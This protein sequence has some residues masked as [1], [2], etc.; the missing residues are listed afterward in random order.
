MKAS[1]TSRLDHN[2]SSKDS[3]FGRFSYDQANSYV[4]G[5]SPTWAEQNPFAS[6]QLIANHGRNAALSET[7]IF[8]SNNINQ[9][10]F[11]YNRIFNFITSFGEFGGQLCK[12]DSLGIV[13]ADLNSICP[14]APPGLTQTTKA[15]LSL[16]VEFDA[17]R[18]LLWFGRSRFCS[19]SR[20]HQRIHVLRYIR[21]D[22]REA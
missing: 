16:R 21:Y 15:C 17:A 6:N 22:S 13:G 19:F 5:G 8:S 4:P 9:I 14:N 11:G 3:A 1:S 7:H 20:R 18:Q 2:F 12:A 10:S